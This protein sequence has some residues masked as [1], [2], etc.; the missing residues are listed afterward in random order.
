[1][2]LNIFFSIKL[3]RQFKGDKLPKVLPKNNVFQ[4]PVRDSWPLSWCASALFT[5]PR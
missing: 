3:I 1:M 2:I 5:D 4:N